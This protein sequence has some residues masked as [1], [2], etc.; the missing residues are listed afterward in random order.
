[1]ANRGIVEF[2]YTRDLPARS[3][4]IAKIQTEPLTPAQL[5]DINNS[6][7]LQGSLGVW[8]SASNYSGAADFVAK[9]LNVSL[10]ISGDTAYRL[11][12]HVFEITNQTSD[13]LTPLYYYHPLEE[14][15]SDVRI[16]DLDNQVV[17]DAV[18]TINGTYLYHD[19]D[20]T[21]A[22]RVRYVTSDG[23]MEVRLL[24]SVP[25]LKQSLYAP[26][27]DAYVFSG[28]II[29]VASTGT[30]YIRFLE[31]NGYRLLAPYDGAPNAPWFVRVRYSL[32]PIAPEWARQIFLP[33]RPYMLG[34][35]VKGKVLDSH[36]IEFERKDM[37]YD[38]DHLPDVVVFDKEYAIKYAIEGTATGSARRRGTLYPWKRGLY[39]KGGIDA[40]NSRVELAVELET[41]D[42][43]FGFYSYKEM[44]VVYRTLDVNPFTN[45]AVKN[46]VI[47][48]YQ[49]TNGSD[50]FRYIYHQVLDS[51]GNPIAGQ[52]ND[53]SPGTGTKHVFATLVVGTSIGPNQFTIEDARSLGGGLAPAYQDIPEAV[54]FWDLGY[55]DG[56]PYPL[57]GSL[58]V[59]LPSRILEK[60]SKSDVA[61]KVKSNLPMGV[62]PVIF[63]YDEDGNESR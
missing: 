35:W 38:P 39:K 33:A 7:Y 8:K 13:T 10:A 32:R 41:T 19:Q 45:P 51:A 25:V 62:L 63:Y 55:W 11:E 17:E 56:K 49:K 3:V 44:D 31:H 15:V 9:D 24:Q 14:G 46:R 60:M 50:P 36:L 28:N 37:F 57:G 54:N 16:L 43:V 4:A 2:Y 20:R 42:V 52:T 21:Q 59:Y 53:P 1:M 47:Q 27:A 34:T 22:F 61:E 30:F 29:T 18:F 23:F 58:V 5:T 26:K 6:P 12:N 48:F 40:Y